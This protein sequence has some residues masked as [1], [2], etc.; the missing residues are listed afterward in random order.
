MNLNN[1]PDI[2]IGGSL[3]FRRA[4]SIVLERG[5]REVCSDIG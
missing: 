4:E 2:K 1:V 5:Y 3:N